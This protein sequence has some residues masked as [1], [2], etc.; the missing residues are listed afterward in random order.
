M[1]MITA[2][3]WV[4]R[5][6]AAENPTQYHVDEKELARIS[7]LAKLQLEDAKDD[8]REAQNGQPERGEERSSSGEEEEEEEDLKMTVANG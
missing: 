7:N 8:L 5:G 2:S 1:S 3:L 6:A 4:P